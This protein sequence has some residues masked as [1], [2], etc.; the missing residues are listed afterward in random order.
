MKD[1]YHVHK[2]VEDLLITEPDTRNSDNVLY[3]MLIT[4]ID[5]HIAGMPFDKVLINRKELGIPSIE[6]V[7]RCRRKIQ[8]YNPLLKGCRKVEDM[9]YEKWKEFMEYASN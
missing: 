2:L 9:R 3:L 1:L 7:G 6:T 8:E 4:Q 5:P